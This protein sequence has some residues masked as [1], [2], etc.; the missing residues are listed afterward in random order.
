LANRK[1]TSRFRFGGAAAAAAALGA[2]G[3]LSR[4]AAVSRRAEIFRA[5]NVS[6]ETYRGERAGSTTRQRDE[7]ERTAVD[8][9]MF[10]CSGE[11]REKREKRVSVT[12][13]TL[14]KN[15]F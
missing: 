1:K 4:R 9:R 13:Q 8:V 6:S 15:V 12:G 10:G 2:A 14:G 3:G 7:E 5:W 11:K